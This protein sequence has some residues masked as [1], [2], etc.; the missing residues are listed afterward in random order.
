MSFKISEAFGF[1]AMRSVQRVIAFG[2]SLA[3]YS[4]STWAELPT[5]PLTLAQA[6][7]RSSEYQQSQ[8]VWQTQQQIAT[9]N[10]KQAKLWIN[11]ELSI[12]Q[13]GFNSDQDRELALGISQ[14]L[15]LFGER[16]A[17]QNYAQI[18]QQQTTLKQQTYQAQLELAVKYL[19]SQLAI[20]ELERQ[21]VQEQR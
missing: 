10:I 6:I 7:Q 16:K 13:T 19:W 20:F 15:D 1:D 3:L 4:Q 17:N 11:P 12:E 18:A 14:R 9:A 5:Q 2:L 8:G 21:V